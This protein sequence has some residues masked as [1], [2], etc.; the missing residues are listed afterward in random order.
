MASVLDPLLITPPDFANYRD[1]SVNLDKGELDP[2]IREAQAFNMRNFLG[3]ILYT[4]LIQDFTPDAGEGTFT[5]DKFTKLWFGQSDWNHGGD[6]IQYNGL[7]PAVIYW[8]FGFMIDNNSVKV[9]R[10][11]LRIIEGDFSEDATTTL[12]R[13]K[14]TKARDNA[15]TYANRADAFIRDQGDIYPDYR[16]FVVHGVRTGRTGFKF[17]MVK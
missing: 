8:A 12:V 5:E 4:E 15:E 9:T 6:I 7:K 16:R 1:I 17:R 10:S 13:D 2:F 3:D 11:G 14:K